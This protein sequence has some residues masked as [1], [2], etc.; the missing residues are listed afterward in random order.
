MEKELFGNFQQ[1]KERVTSPYEFDSELL[2]IN[3]FE[4]EFV[5]GEKRLFISGNNTFW[6]SFD[7]TSFLAMINTDVAKAINTCKGGFS[8]VFYDEN[9]QFTLVFSDSFGL[10]PIYFVHDPYK[11][12]FSSS[13]RRILDEGIIEKEIDA[14][15]LLDYFRFGSFLPGTTLFRGV[16]QLQPGNYLRISEDNF[17]ENTYFSWNKRFISNFSSVE[18]VFAE[19]DHRKAG[20][21][22]LKSYP[23][24]PGFKELSAFVDTIDVPFTPSV[25]STLSQPG[26]S[27]VF[28]AK[29]IFEGIPELNRKKWP[30]SF[31]P[32]LRTMIYRLGLWRWKGLEGEW[33][34]EK[35][36]QEYWD[37]EFLYQ[38]NYQ[39]VKDGYLRKVFNWDEWPKNGVFT[40]LHDQLGYGK[41]GYAYPVFGRLSLAEIWISLLSIQVPFLRYLF[42][43]EGTTI[44]YPNLDKELYMYVMSVPDGLKESEYQGNIANVYAKDAS[45]ER[46]TV[47]MDSVSEKDWTAFASGIQYLPYCNPKELLALTQSDS[48]KYQHILIL[49]IWLEQVM[50]KVN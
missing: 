23:D 20:I 44:D 50:N 3:G 1:I 18:Q 28:A 17:S 38:F 40:F 2:R 36:Q 25:I 29:E 7:S 14:T 15:V 13:L 24:I 35:L 32:A 22:G 33:K 37:I 46:V 49:G 11:A 30:M 34:K 10:F 42:Q 12:F 26:W 39:I 45:P 31:S 6:K 8:G 41:D 19:I 43:R 27:E 21:E 47:S 48:G 16:Y 4:K 5:Q 9:E